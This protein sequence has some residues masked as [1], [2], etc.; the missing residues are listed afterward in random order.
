VDVG[1]NNSI[2]KK[3]GEINFSAA[4]PVLCVQNIGGFAGK[5]KVKIYI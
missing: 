1:P 4:N 3:A 5:Y 2:A